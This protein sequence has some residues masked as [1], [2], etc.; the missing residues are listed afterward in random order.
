[1]TDGITDRFM[2]E[3]RGEA[4]AE[5]VTGNVVCDQLECDIIIGDVTVKEK[6]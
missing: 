1:M 5:S 4:K 2:L 6:K 3:V